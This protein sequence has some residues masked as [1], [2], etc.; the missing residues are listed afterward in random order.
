MVEEDAQDE[1]HA[2]KVS[3]PGD[4]SG[5]NG[6][7]IGARLRGNRG[8]Q[9]QGWGCTVGSVRGLTVQVRSGERPAGVRSIPVRTHEARW[10]AVCSS[11]N[12]RGPRHRQRGTS[13]AV[14]LVKMLGG[15]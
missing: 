9:R 4:A 11:E 5:V 14:G 6:L 15:A 2:A 8:G 1:A 10:R 3:S 7:L 13:A 12:A